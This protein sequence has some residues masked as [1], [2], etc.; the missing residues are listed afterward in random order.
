MAS[1]AEVLKVVDVL[2]DT[3]YFWHAIIYYYY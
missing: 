1:S 3:F 2:G